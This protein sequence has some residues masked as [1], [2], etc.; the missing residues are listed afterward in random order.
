MAKIFL[1]KNET[2]TIGSGHNDIFGQDGN[3]T[4]V[5]PNTALNNTVDQNVENIV[6]SGSSSDYLYQQTGNKLNVY[7]GNVLLFSVPVQDDADG[8]V[9]EFDNGSFSAKL[10]GGVLTLG[11][12]TVP[13]DA[14]GPVI[15]D[16]L[17]P[18]Y[19]LSAS[20]VVV[21]ETNNNQVTFTLATTNVAAGTQV[22]YD[23]SG[24][25]I[26]PEDVV[27]GQ[28]TGIFTVGADGQATAVVILAA[29]LTTEGLETLVLSLPGQPSVPPVSVDVQDTSVAPT[30]PTYTVTAEPATS[31]DEG[32]SVSFTLATQGVAAGTVVPYHL[33]GQGIDGN[34]IVGGNL[35]GSFIVGVTDTVTIAI[36]ADHVTEGTETLTLALDPSFANTS[37]SVQ[38]NDTSVAPPPTAVITPVP[39]DTLHTVNL[40]L[41]T[42]DGHT[43]LTGNDVVADGTSNPTLRLTGDAAI[44]INVT[45]AASQVQGIDLNGDGAIASNGV[46]NDVSGAGIFT[47][48]NFTIFD[49]Y[50]RNPLNEGDSVKNY[51]GDLYYE[52]TGYAGNGTSTNGNI[53]LG[54]L[55]ADN[56]FGGLGNDFL[57]G[58]AVAP[59]R[60]L[61]QVVSGVKVLVDGLTGQPVASWDPAAKLYTDL[62]SG[63]PFFTDQVHGGRNADF[64]FAELSA[65]NNTD[66]NLTNYDGGNSTDS[67]SAGLAE[68]LSG[69]NSQNNDWILLEAHDDNEPVTVYLGDHGDED[70]TGS[71]TLRD[72]THVGALRNIESVD[73]SGNLYGFLNNSNAELGSRVTDSRIPAQVPGQENFSVGSTAQLDI[74]GNDAANAVIAGYDNDS[75]DGADGADLLFGG[76]LSY[77]LYNKNN[78]NLLDANGGLNLNVHAIKQAADGSVV[79]VVND[80]RDEIYG[81]DGNDSIVFE[82]DGG[83]YDGGLFGDVPGTSKTVF[84]AD[85]L[86][87]TNFSTGRIQGATVAGEAA[88]QG[89]ENNFGAD[90][91]GQAQADTLAALTTDNRVRLDLGVGQYQVFFNYGGADKNA[92]GKA[93]GTIGTSTTADQTN[94]EAGVSRTVVQGIDAVITTGLGDIDF[95]ADGQND[96]P[97]DPTVSDARFQQNFYGLN[98]DVDLRGV[99]G[100]NDDGLFGY[101]ID[102]NGDVSDELDTVPNPADNILYANTGNDI[103]EGRGGNDQL[104]GGQNEGNGKGDDFVFGLH[105]GDDVDTIHRQADV[106]GNSLWDKDASGNYQY[107]Q[108]FRVK[109]HVVA[110]QS[111]T[112]EAVAT[113]TAADGQLQLQSF[114][115]TVEGHPN[116]SV[117]LTSAHTIAQVEALV[118]LA[119]Q[120]LGLTVTHLGNFPPPAGQTGGSFTIT[121]P[122]GRSFTQVGF[123]WD[124]STGTGTATQNYHDG[125]AST[126]TDEDDR[127]IFKDYLDR[128]SNQ[129][130]DD[131]KSAL[132]GDAYANH[133]VA[134]FIPGAP[135]ENATTVLAE[136]QEWRIE[137]QNLNVGDTVT[138]NVNG[139]VF[140]ARVGYDDN[141]LL[142]YPHETTDAF[143]ARLAA[144]F[145]DAGCTDTSAT[146][147]NINAE[148]QENIAN[149]SNEEVLVLWQ[150]NDTVNGFGAG[151]FTSKPVVSINGVANPGTVQVVDTSDNTINLYQF[152]GRNNELNADDALF[153]GNSTSKTGDNGLD[154]SVS[155]SILATAKDAGGVLNGKDALTLTLGGK[156]TQ[157]HGNDLLIGGI[158]SDTINGLGGND[159]IMGSK[160]HDIVDGGEDA[161]ATTQQVFNNLNVP[162]TTD[163][164]GNGRIDYTDTLVFR[165][166]DFGT[167]SNGADGATFTISIDDTIGGTGKGTVKASDGS[168][169]DFTNIEFVR[170]LSN[171]RNDTLDAKALSDKIA[172]TSGP[173]LLAG[174][175]TTGNEGVNLSLTHGVVEVRYNV[176]RNNDNILT[177]TTSSAT[178]EAALLALKVLGIENIKTGNANDSLAVDESQVCV[179]NNF[180]L[181]GN[182]D[183]SVPPLPAGL[184]QGKDVL[185]YDHTALVVPNDTPTTVDDDYSNLPTLA[186]HVESAANVDTVD[187]TG[188]IIPL[189]ETDTDTVTGAEVIDVSAAAINHEYADTL[190]V[191]TLDATGATINYG[192]DV[193]VGKTLGGGND[194]VTTVAQLNA[195]TLVKGG[196]SH[197]GDGLGNEVLTVDGIKYLEQVTGS[198]GNDRVILADSSALQGGIIDPTLV[199]VDNNPATPP[200]ASETNDRAVIAE[201]DLGKATYLDQNGLNP[202]GFA[203][204]VNKGLY[205]FNLGD[206]SNDT[207][208][209]VQETGTVAVLLDTTGTT[210]KDW[211]LVDGN[212]NG[213]LLDFANDGAKTASA[214]SDRVDY[215]NDVERY[216]GGV[217]KATNIIDLSDSTL[218]TTIQFS[219]EADS[220]TPPNEYKEPNGSDGKATTKDQVRGIE[221]R[222]TTATSTVPA[223]TVFAN[224]MDRTVADPTGT[225][226]WTK[227]VGSDNAETVVLTNNEKDANHDFV[228]GKGADVVNYTAL[229]KAITA[230]IGG[231]VPNDVVADKTVDSQTVTVTGANVAPDQDTILVTAANYAAGEKTLTVVAP[232]N[233]GASDTVDITPLTTKIDSFNLVDLVAGVVVEDT[234]NVKA[235]EKQGNVIHISGFEDIVGSAADDHLFGSD[236]VNVITGNDGNDW[237]VGRGGVSTGTIF[238]ADFGDQLSGDSAF[239]PGT[240]G[241]DRFILEQ[242]SDSYAGAATGFRA[243]DLVT[244]FNLG[245]LNQNR[246][247]LVFNTTD[248]GAVGKDALETTISD[249]GFEYDVN[250]DQNGDGKF[251]DT[252]E[253]KGDDAYRVWDWTG[254]MQATNVVLRVSQSDGADIQYVNKP[255]DTAGVGAV[256]GS[257]EVVYTAQP[258]STV[259]ARD[260]FHGFEIGNVISAGRD[261]V[262][263]TT[264]NFGQIRTAA[265]DQFTTTVDASGATV[266]TLGKDGIADAIQ[267]IRYTEPTSVDGATAVANFFHD[268]G[269]GALAGRAIHVQREGTGGNDFRV[270]V[271]VDRDGN[272][273]PAKDLV[274]D[275]NGVTLE[276]SSTS[277]LA[278][279]AD[280]FY[281]DADGNG[282]D[283]P[284]VVPGPNNDILGDSG[285]FILTNGQYVS[286]WAIQPI[287]NAAP[288]SITGTPFPDTLDAS[289]RTDGITLLGLGSDDILIGGSGN[290]TLDGG[291]GADQMTGNAGDDIY[292]VDNAGDTVTE[293]PGGGTDTIKS[294][295]DYTLSANVEN[296]VA[297]A[298]GIT[299]NGNGLD[300]KLSVDPSVT[301]GVTLDGKVGNDTIDGGVGNDTLLGGAGNDIIHGGAGDDAIDGGDGID[302]LFGDAGNDTL[303]GGNGQD[304]LFGGEGNDTLNGG[305]GQDALYGEAGDD[306]FV[307]NG[308]TGGDNNQDVID[309]GDGVDTLALSGSYTPTAGGL[310]GTPPVAATADDTLKNVELVTLAALGGA[311]VDL[312]SQTEAFTATVLDGN[313]ETILGGS[314]DDTLNG[315]AGD[316][317]LDGGVGN[318]VI[319]GNDGNDVLLGGEGT[320]TLSGGAGDDTLDGGDA[321]DILL[322]GAGDDTLI[323]GLGADTLQGGAD[324]DTYFVDDAGDAVTENANE[325][326]DTV[327]ASISYT[328]TANVENLTLTGTDNIN[329]TGNALAN[330]IIG[331]SGDNI[332]DGGAGDGVADTL[333][334]GAGNDIYVVDSTL[335]TIDELNNGGAGTDEVQSSVSYSLAAANVLG[336]VE[337]L[338]LTGSG[339]IDGTGN[340]LA[341]LITGNSGANILDGGAGDAAIDSLRGGAGNDVYVVDNTDDFVDESTGAG[342]DT[343]RSSVTYSLAG[344]QVL[345]AV[346]NLTL[347]GAGNIDGTGNALDN[348]ITGNSGNNTLDGGTGKDTLIGGDG[349]DLY[350]VDDAADVV[351]EADGPNGGIDTV[352]SQVNYT[353]SANVENLT[354]LAGFAAALNGTGNGQDNTI[355]GNEFAN[356]LTGGEGADT[357]NGGEGADQLLGDQG[358]DTLNGGDGNDQLDGG[359]GAD[360]LNG[361]AGADALVG[362]IGD[363]QLNGGDDDDTL[364]GDAGNDILRGDAGNDQLLGG[365]GDDDLDGGAGNDTLVGG[366]GDDIYHIDDLGDVVTEQAGEGT[367]L[368]LSSI[369]FDLT[370]QAGTLNVE[371]LTLLPGFPGAITGI[372]N[373]LANVI[374][375]NEFNNILDGGLGADTLQ[376]GAGD[377]TYFVDNAGDVVSELPGEGTDL[378][379]ATVS[380]TIADP[381]VENLTLAGGAAA[382]ITGTGNSSA[383][384]ITGN[385]FN[386][387]LF[388]LDGDDTLSGDA[389]ADVLLGGAGAD[390]LFGGDGNDTLDGGAGSD[391]LTGNAGLDN[392]RF[393]TPLADEGVDTIQDFTAGD[394][395]RFSQAVYTSLPV[396]FPLPA[397]NFAANATAAPADGNDYILYN[398]GA[399]SESGFVYYD[400][401]GNGSAFAPVHIATVVGTP[402]LTAAN[403]DVVA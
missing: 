388:G 224:F 96:A 306:T 199:D 326:D 3:E 15:P 130:V 353:L 399:G 129:G 110:G 367:D 276:G 84:A 358:A 171:T 114:N 64:T 247:L 291:T 243:Q 121:D 112:V 346:E 70:P 113:T 23:L 142:A 164:N 370:S 79:N 60:F 294:S 47:A 320:D 159:V 151:V 298:G 95:R 18:T 12:G 168:V 402:A 77:L 268:K 233:S 355:I 230:T 1:D 226:Y 269:D 177:N 393:T 9:I 241:A 35:T 73:A 245:G 136:G 16:P 50:A 139:Q 66:G 382:A 190:D 236:Q 61:A 261:R 203:N 109:G 270:F 38:I 327:N 372:G 36:K 280:N 398:N 74:I 185:S 304:A 260:E 331:N 205:Q 403:F 32:A 293:Q 391:T 58:G 256:D 65:L 340:A 303:N 172:A 67:A 76:N 252:G 229:T 137:F 98:A 239:G 214:T 155:W 265:D 389:G 152:D 227:V 310:S 223:G 182:V 131:Q 75:I 342:I 128:Q 274:F 87:L 45:N 43:L 68:S 359:E 174:D 194:P 300:N 228:L 321:N 392:F 318:D 368:I 234:L 92:D 33:I 85:S 307:L 255:F 25:G 195:N 290:D 384:V 360:I 37:A 156:Q 119:V 10:S 31:V 48:K 41:D 7:L 59:G 235:A 56:I 240:A 312:T 11:D 160:G 371:N 201:Q 278:L 380:Y 352:E 220:N 366:T 124:P 250:I 401:D 246:D 140:E 141:G 209:Y 135:G 2:S 345:G 93:I 339:N 361:G 147:G 329:G 302:T 259:A 357:L 191:S 364:Q 27:G 111:T 22:A 277:K 341:N 123:N 231:V 258:Q 63:Q 394:I 101:A 181:G 127:L 266:T 132:H 183:Q 97:F 349:D 51:L 264:F 69:V 317:T 347:T 281:H 149:A 333:Q 396:G 86:Y 314:G 379:G 162:Y 163:D 125:T 4:V 390:T 376:G 107:T 14:P 283:G 397:A 134:E 53:V 146:S 166:Q 253:N 287:T 94:Y 8:T 102:S 187:A 49:A 122:T 354:L 351:I 118:A 158:G 106:D 197:T 271:D 196:I 52:G 313:G 167:G 208:D 254:E 153:V 82:A 71:I 219:K 311:I 138:V 344:A 377:D 373:A 80:G 343:V 30:A 244:D 263:L 144:K 309:G 383:N 104:S 192:S 322:G 319:N 42:N 13:P 175:P 292:I 210:S 99:D 24:V 198:T 238:G 316:D 289:D 273:D 184:L 225:S 356:H 206:G 288:G 395:I 222:A 157:L 251:A 338:T 57:A 179:D 375:G 62:V 26:T 350:R 217:G 154:A 365:L 385:E 72:G 207:L 296:G 145:S 200:V 17:V 178:D 400:A 173:S 186:I 150:A 323:G 242:E 386:N 374:T 348:T 301:K 315:G 148:A 90:H 272:Y 126:T 169:T 83:V 202:N 115:I 108:D 369:S 176:D 297:L 143:V 334:G 362:G 336:D 19:H 305:N 120:P 332:L 381:D 103:I 279:T 204:A 248:S 378:V 308:A 81:G 257:F 193:A 335:D 55:G 295:V 363:D 133:L 88:G 282:K 28:L 44:H 39:D 6:L 5:I 105:E 286:N 29:D 34:D 40:A 165:E 275:L 213:S 237:V 212:A 89:G 218:D 267:T 216:F 91:G 189:G 325:G 188:G 215:A 387:T 78:P 116:V 285:V 262:D 54:G 20:P 46:E 161:A 221:V 330:T 180:D 211:V 337:N 284:V 299:L 328:L 100:Y 117:D 324:N 249:F 232:N 170:T 21:N